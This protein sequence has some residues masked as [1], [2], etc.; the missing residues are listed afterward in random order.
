VAALEEIGADQRE[1]IATG[2]A[3]TRRRVWTLIESRHG[4]IP[5]SRVADVDLGSTTVIRL[6]ATIQIAHSDKEQA[7][8]TFKE[9]L[10]ASPVDRV[11]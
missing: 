2:R 8:G 9:H 1:R 7:T 10:R 6:D 4:G 3:K 5:P 11:V